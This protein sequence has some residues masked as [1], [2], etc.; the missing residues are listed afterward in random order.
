MKNLLK[1]EEA[2]LALALSPKTL[3]RWI[4]ERRISVVKVGK[5]VRIE[6]AELERITSEGRR[7]RV[8]L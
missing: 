3:R 8:I 2:A 7:E 6:A 1:I 4:W 5:A